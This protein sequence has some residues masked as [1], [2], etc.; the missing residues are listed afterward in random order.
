MSKQT[1]REYLIELMVSDD[2]AQAIQDVKQAA[3]SPDRYKKQQRAQTVDVQKEIQ[4]DPNDP[5]K[6]DKLRLAKMKQQ[7]SS[8]ESRLTRKEKQMARRAGVAPEEGRV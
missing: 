5:L 8:Q 7:I 2:P 3:R 6:S 4:K 1:F